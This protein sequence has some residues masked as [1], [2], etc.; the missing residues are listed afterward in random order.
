MNVR[1]KV[2]IH[3][4]RRLGEPQGGS[5]LCPVRSQMLGYAALTEP[6][7]RGLADAAGSLCS[8]HAKILEGEP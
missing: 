5:L 4:S 7:R 1:R 8:A 3:Q 6:A 2:G